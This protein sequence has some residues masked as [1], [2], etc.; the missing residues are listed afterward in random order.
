MDNYIDLVMLV[1][2]SGI[3]FL[4]LWRWILDAIWYLSP[5]LWLVIN[6]GTKHKIADDEFYARLA[7][8]EEKHKERKG[9]R[10]SAT[11]IQ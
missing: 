8:R 9:K 4:L 3:A 5:R 11:K 7:E 6:K 10:G 1:L 2:V